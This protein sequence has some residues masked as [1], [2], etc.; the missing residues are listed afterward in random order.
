MAIA[1]LI[2]DPER[3][4]NNLPANQDIP[5]HARR[6]FDFAAAFERARAQGIIPNIQH[7]PLEQRIIQQIPMEIDEL[8][9]SDMEIDN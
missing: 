8:D 1:L 7:P 2:F 6:G 5:L 3:I 4:N 9:D